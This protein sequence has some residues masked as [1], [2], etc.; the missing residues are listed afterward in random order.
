MSEVNS[1]APRSV[2]Y[3]AYLV[4]VALAYYVVAVVAL[5]LLEPGLDPLVRPISAYLRTDHAVTATSTF[6]ALAVA[7][8]ALS[9]GLYRMRFRGRLPVVGLGL[10]GL[11][12]VGVVIAGLFPRPPLHVVGGLMTIPPTLVAVLMMS[13]TFRR[14]P[15]WEA[16]A[17]PL[18]YLGLLVVALFV[19]AV[20]VLERLDLGGLGQ[21]LFFA[22]LFTWMAM[23]AWRIASPGPR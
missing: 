12:A 23:V 17:S 16:S 18:L 10:L 8:G 20:A 6:F 15:G 22:A 9:V 1:P 3:P 13:A 2:R 7:L 11:A 14:A 21:R 19:F 4:L 5:H